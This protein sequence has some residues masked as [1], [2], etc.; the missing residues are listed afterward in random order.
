MIRTSTDF[1]TKNFLFL[2]FIGPRFWRDC[3]KIVIGSGIS[4]FLD[5]AEANSTNVDGVSGAIRL[6]RKRLTWTIYRPA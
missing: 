6:E 2:E 5:R 3:R 1:L 4:R